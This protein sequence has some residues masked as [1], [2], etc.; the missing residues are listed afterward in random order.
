MKSIGG[1]FELELPHHG[2]S[3]H[4]DAIM[5]STGRA[6]LMVILSEIKPKLVHV[7]FHTC[8]ATLE[9]FKLKDVETRYYALNEKMEPSDLPELGV[10]EF[11]LWTNYYGLCG[12]QTDELKRHYGGRLI[13]DDTHAFFHGAHGGHWSFTSARKYFGV[14]D[15]AFLFAPHAI[16]LQPPRFTGVSM[17][18]SILRSLGFQQRAFEAYQLYEN[19]LTCNVNGISVVSEGL[20]KGIDLAETM[21]RRT[22]NYAFLSEQIGHLNRISIE[23]VD[24]DVP[25][26]YPFLP[27]VA[28]DRS[29]F[30]EQG[31]FVPRLWPDAS[32]RNIEGFE[33]EKRLGTDLLPLPIDH[34]YTPE[35]LLP[36][37]EHIKRGR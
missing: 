31:F 9:P 10:G 35:D 29:K 30:Y 25:Y 27:E 3:P 18:H 24:N 8:N 28:M 20:L 19:S 2:S 4:P 12:R 7:P 23:R 34:R 26:C 6:C 15:G 13:I 16:T 33:W 5:L 11:F 32:L 36:L 21:R 1:F 37:V 17:D 14:P 22:T